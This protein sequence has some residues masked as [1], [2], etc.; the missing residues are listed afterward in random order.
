MGDMSRCKHNAFQSYCRLCNPVEAELRDEITALTIELENAEEDA[1][2]Y[3]WILSQAKITD[4]IFA[5]TKSKERHISNAID[6]MKESN[7][8]NE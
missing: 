4:F 1:E 3:K 8:A 5:Y 2:R 7:H 6:T